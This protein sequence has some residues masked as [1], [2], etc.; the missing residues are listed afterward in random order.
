MCKG[1]LL[2]GLLHISSGYYSNAS[3]HT[4]KVIVKLN[5]KRRTNFNKIAQYLKNIVHFTKKTEDEL[6]KTIFTSLEDYKCYK[7]DCKD[8]EIH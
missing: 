5:E 6:E 4:N 2:M 7:E 8:R 1:E 3:N